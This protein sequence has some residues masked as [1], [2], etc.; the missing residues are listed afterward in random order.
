MAAFAWV[1]IDDTARRPRPLKRVREVFGYISVPYLDTAA[2]RQSHREGKPLEPSAL[3]QLHS[4]R[5]AA[6]PKRGAP[7]Y[8]YLLAVP[9]AKTSSAAQIDGAL[10]FMRQIFVRGASADYL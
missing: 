3:R 1:Q 5:G 7:A 6:P 8:S 10:R 2:R 4:T 9:D